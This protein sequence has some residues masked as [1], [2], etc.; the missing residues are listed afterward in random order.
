MGW[1]SL[2]TTRRSI[3]I[4]LPVL[5]GLLVI[6]T[7]TAQPQIPATYFGTATIDGLNAPDGTQVRAFINGKDCTQPN[8]PGTITTGGVSSYVILV[9][10]DSQA[11][12]CG[13]DGA[14]VSFK[15][16]D[17]DAGQTAEWSAGVQELNLNAGAGSPVALPT[18]TETPTV[19]PAAATAAALRTAEA[20]TP[21]PTDD[22]SVLEPAIGEP[23]TLDDGGSSSLIAWVAIVLGVLA[24]GGAVAGWALSRKRA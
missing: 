21:P 8:S 10:H 12:G 6:A 7:A 11:D 1:V 15:I 19:D 14:L 13:S 18:P 4:C 2:R 22:P 23:V 9:M 3:A 20:G 17:A 5:G 24:L 16:G